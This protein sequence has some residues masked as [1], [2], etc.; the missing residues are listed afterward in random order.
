MAISRENS[1]KTVISKV[2]DSQ[3]FHF[4]YLE[5]SVRFWANTMLSTSH[6]NSYLHFYGIYCI[7]QL[8]CG[9]LPGLL[10]IRQH[11]HITQAVHDVG[12]YGVRFLGSS[13]VVLVRHA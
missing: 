3:R 5:R 10:G 6:Q 1:V 11:L 7:I 4:A 13:Q 9:S 2:R 8:S 12:R